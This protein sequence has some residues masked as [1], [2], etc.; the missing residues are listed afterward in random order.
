MES[1]FTMSAE[2]TAPD[3]LKGPTPRRILLTMS[4]IQMAM[5]VAI[6]FALAAAGFVW[7][8][9]D[10]GFQS[11]RNSDFSQNG[12]QTTASI[13]RVQHSGSLQPRVDYTFT[14]GDTTYTGVARVPKQF[15]HSLAASSSL[16]VL[17]LP[18][19][20]AINRPAAWQPPRRSDLALLV[21]PVLA[22]LLGLLLFVPLGVEYRMASQGTPVVA[23]VRECSLARNG[24]LVRYEF[25]LQDNSLIKGRGWYKNHQ[26]PGTGIWVMY[27]PDRPQRNL[28]YPLTYCRA[29]R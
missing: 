5:A 7:V 27:L 17:Y 4:G 3:E 16:A 18:S 20:P 9:R 26:Q 15:A 19:D 24:F 12:R 21:A 25:R 11:R 1:A 10:A 23:V 2:L 29:V 13:T 6:L 22:A 14:A 8:S 28:P